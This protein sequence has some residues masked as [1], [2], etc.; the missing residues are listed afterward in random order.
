MFGDGSGAFPLRQIESHP[1]DTVIP[2]D[3]AMLEANNDGHIDMLVAG[4]IGVYL[5]RR[6]P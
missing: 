1:A 6:I 3:L 2:R 4:D 5:E